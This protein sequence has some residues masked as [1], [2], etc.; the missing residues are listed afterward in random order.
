MASFPQLCD[1][2]PPERIACARWEIPRNSQKDSQAPGIEADYEPDRGSMPD[3]YLRDK[4]KTVTGKK[5]G[6]PFLTYEGNRQIGG[7]SQRNLFS[8]HKSSESSRR[9]SAKTAG[10][11]ENPRAYTSRSFRYLRAHAAGSESRANSQHRP[12]ISRHYAERI[13]IVYARQS[14]RRIDNRTHLIDPGH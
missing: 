6:S 5:G 12:R 11:Q 10:R 8:P 3:I 4:N 13:E 1:K 2:E 7:Q 14:L 9:S